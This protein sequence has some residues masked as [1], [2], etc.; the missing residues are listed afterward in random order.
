[1]RNWFI[2][3]VS[4]G[5][6]RAL[7]E[8]VLAHGDSVTGTLRSREACD[9]FAALVPGRSRAALLD[10]TDLDGV[11]AAIEEAERAGGGIDI[12]V[13]NAGYSFEGT[14]EAA[15][16]EEIRAQFETNLF[17]PIAFIK[18][19]LPFMRA[20]RHGH[21]F[22][23]GSMAAHVA[24]DGIAIYGSVKLALEALSEGLAREVESFGIRVTMVVPGA[25]RTELGSSRRSAAANIL[26]YAALD[27]HRRER[28]AQLSGTQRGD[29]RKAAAAIL[30]VLDTPTPPFRLV[31]GPDAV[32]GLRVKFVT[33]V[34]ELARWDTLSKSTDLDF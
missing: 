13:N 3:G 22:N 1:V 8:A 27:R 17:G 11:R 16:F 33:A 30:A 10:V 6:G 25:F 2:T 20:R 21:I 29:P 26:D 34:Q 15:S 28:L 7:A 5:L 23:V 32:D 19:V 9:R 31:L 4:S 14:V 24:S 18:A 12:L